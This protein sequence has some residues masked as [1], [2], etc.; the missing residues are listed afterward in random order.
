LSEA[1]AGLGRRQDAQRAQLRAKEL[2]NSKRP[3]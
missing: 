2:Q 3:Q 1:Y